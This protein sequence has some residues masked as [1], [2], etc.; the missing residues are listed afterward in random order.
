MT[1]APTSDNNIAFIDVKDPTIVN[2]TNF[3][4]YRFVEYY[5]KSALTF[6]IPIVI[7]AIHNVKNED[8][9]VK[10]D[11]RIKQM[12]W[13]YGW[14]PL[15][16]TD[17]PDKI[18]ELKTKGFINK[19]RRFIIG[20]ISQQ[21]LG[22]LGHD[23]YFLLCKRRIGNSLCIKSDKTK[24]KKINEKKIPLYYNSYKL[25]TL[26]NMTISLNGKDTN[27]RGLTFQYE[28]FKNSYIYPLY[29]VKKKLKF[30]A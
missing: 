16:S 5:I 14:F 12:Q 28:L 27:V 22:T 3:S 25:L 21:E 26:D 23:L 10:F 2:W 8:T 30:F 29:V 1:L 17:Y 4:S 11:D 15:N 18:G 24:D 20:T 13:T 7:E 6:K 19:K 9:L